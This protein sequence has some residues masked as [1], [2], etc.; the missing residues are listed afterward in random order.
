MRWFV[1]VSH[2][3]VNPSAAIPDYA[4]DAPPRP[5]PPYEE[6]I[7][8]QQWVRHPPDPYQIISNDAGGFLSN[9]IVF[10]IQPNLSNFL[11]LSIIISFYFIST[12]G[13]VISFTI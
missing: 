3:I 9:F 6:V 12:H 5:V 4:A 7:V 8:E 13:F 11:E 10:I 1:R 2:P